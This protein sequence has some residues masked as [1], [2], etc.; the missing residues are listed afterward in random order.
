MSLPQ[1]IKSIG[2]EAK[3]TRANGTVEDL[4][5]VAFAHQDPEEEARVRAL[6]P[7]WGDKGTIRA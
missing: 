4:G 7:E 5:L 2:L 6:H 3:I 1:D